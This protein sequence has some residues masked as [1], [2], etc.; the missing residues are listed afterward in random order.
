[1]LFLAFFAPLSI[2]LHQKLVLPRHIDCPARA[3]TCERHNVRRFISGNVLSARRRSNVAEEFRWTCTDGKNGKNGHSSNTDSHPLPSEFALKVPQKDFSYDP[4][5]RALPL[6]VIIRPLRRIRENDQA[7]VAWL[8]ESIAQI[9]QQDP[10]DILEVE[11]K[12]YGFNG[13]HRFEAC[14]KLQL[15]FI[16]CKVRKAPRSVLDMHMR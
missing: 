16:W 8:M 12:F 3:L 9:G 14:E 4:K 13:C 7:K 1:M 5:V 10:I 6:N 11:G 2:P 15:P